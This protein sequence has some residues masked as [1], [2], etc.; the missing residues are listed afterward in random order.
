[1]TGRNSLY[2]RVSVCTV[3]FVRLSSSF[4]T[5]VYYCLTNYLYSIEEL[6]KTEGGKKEDVKTSGTIM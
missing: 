4:C 2:Q 1:M 3:V 6:L 5:F